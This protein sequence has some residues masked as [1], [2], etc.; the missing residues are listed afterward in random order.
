[1]RAL[2]WLLV[3]GLLAPAHAEKVDVRTY[4]AKAYLKVS[5]INGTDY[6]VVG[7]TDESDSYVDALRGDLQF[8]FYYSS[9]SNFMPNNWVQQRMAANLEAYRLPDIKVGPAERKQ[10]IN[11]PLSASQWAI[12]YFFHGGWLV[13]LAGAGL[14]WMRRRR[15]PENSLP[16]PSFH[17][18]RKRLGRYTLE[19]SLGKGGFGEV[20]LARDEEGQQ[21]AVKVLR[22][23]LAE[24]ETAR[25]RFFREVE[26]LCKLR[27]PNIIYI[28]DWGEWEGKAFLSMEYLQ[29]EPLGALLARGQRLDKELLISLLTDLGSALDAIHAQGL[30][31]RDIKPDNIFLENSGRFKL[32]DFGAALSDNL[33]RATQTGATMGT[34]AY[35]A[36]EHFQGELNPSSDQYSL[37]VMVYLLLCGRR[38]FESPDPLALAY[39]HLHHD[40]PPPSSIDAE[41]SPEVDW[42]L[43]RMLSKKSS[44][45]YASVGE[46]VDALRAAL[47]D[48]P[49]GYDD[50]T[51]GFVV[52]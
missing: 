9:W 25:K 18:K 5:Q 51:T 32:M 50:A 22:H 21:A 31:H 46:A 39:A 26:V 35:M 48:R 2:C 4:P 15:L 13:L 24:D 44:G 38:P 14:A 36:P 10:V 29:G 41:I 49:A 8:C 45:R 40:P 7:W 34:P 3:L 43:L 42:V 20:Y 23:E 1:M 37:A 17:D 52:S 11:L 16:E 33:T 12:Y 28:Y 19:S 30:V 6:D 47:G 27:H